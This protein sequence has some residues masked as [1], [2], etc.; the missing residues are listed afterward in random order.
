M[1]VNVL[2]RMTPEQEPYWESFLYDGP[3]DNTVA[4]LLDYINYNDDILNDKGE[5]TTRI[6][7]ECSCIQGICGA[8]AMIVNDVPVLAC[9]AFLKDIQGEEISLKPLSKFPVIRDL[10]VDRSGIYDSLRHNNVCIETYKPPSDGDH[11]QDYAS[12]KCLKCGLCIEVC[13]KYTDGRTFYGAPFANDCYLVASRNQEKS[14]EILEIYQ[15]HFK[16]SCA[17]DLA[18]MRI[19]PMGIK[20]TA[21][22]KK[23]NSLK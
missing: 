21:C 11:E 17:F 5:K 9:E 3:E 23:L 2:R 18:C 22:M 12:A 16:D 19:C 6:S 13:P 15:E 10:V 14:H 4:G 1:K 20:I 7:W 8:C